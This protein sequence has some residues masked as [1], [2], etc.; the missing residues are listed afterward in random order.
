M[1]EVYRAT[2]T[3][4]GRPVAVKVCKD[5]FSERVG[6]EARAVAALNHPHICQLYDVGPNYLVMELVDG[7]PIRPTSDPQSLLDLAYQITAGLAAAHAAGIVH[8]DLKPG[9]ILVTRDGQVKILDFGLATHAR[10]GVDAETLPTEPPSER[11]AGTAAYMSPEQARG[12]AVDARSDLWS[13]GVVLYELATGR[14]PFLGA[15]NAMLFEAIL[16]QQP[17]PI[18]AGTSPA[19]LQLAP[20]ID[21]LLDKDRDLRYQSAPDLRAD[22]KRVAHGS[23]S[24][25]ATAAAPPAP[26]RSRARA[27]ILAAGL[28]AAAVGLVAWW[29]AA[30]A[31]LLTDQD[32]LVVADFENRT[33]TPDIELALR[34]ALSSS[35]RSR[36]F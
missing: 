26:G 1:G 23:G 25:S 27:V 16:H 12:D 18:A 30:P 24:G 2:D 13:L 9:N 22:L 8:R 10:Q 14:R 7:G 17:A 15:T 20:I 3:R 11:G 32:V 28:A 31:P 5:E 21:R 4:L 36:R 35:W 19:L 33:T 29:P 6:R 34:Q